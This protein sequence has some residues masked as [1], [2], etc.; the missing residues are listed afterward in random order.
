VRQSSITETTQLSLS[1][2]FVE[3]AMRRQIWWNEY[4]DWCK[5]TAI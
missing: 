5:G 3:E 2:A 4:L 1:N